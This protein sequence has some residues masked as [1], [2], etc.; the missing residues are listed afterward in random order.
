MDSGVGGLAERWAEG[1]RNDSRE[2]SWN[3]V[4]EVIVQVFCSLGWQWRHTEA[5]RE[6]VEDSRDWKVQFRTRRFL[7]QLKSLTE[8][9]INYTNSPELQKYSN[10]SMTS[11][12]V[13]II[14]NVAVS[15]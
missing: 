14:N 11:N 8:L 9:L 1:Q 15:P 10:A 5:S 7:L 4:V 6:K 2:Y 12:N 3:G 13:K